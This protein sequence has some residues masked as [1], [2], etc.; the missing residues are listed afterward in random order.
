MGTFLPVP[1]AFDV[2]VAGALLSGGLEHGYVFALVFTLGSFSIYSWLIVGS[3]ISWRAA[4]LLGGVIVMLGALGGVATHYYH[5]WQTERA[6][7]MLL[8]A[9]RVLLPAAH[10]AGAQFAVTSERPVAVEV[11]PFAPRS[12]GGTTP[13]QRMDAWHAGID[14]PIEFSMKDMWPPFWEGRS[15]S[16]G[17]IDQDG[18]TDLVIASTEAGLYIYD[19]GGDGQFTRIGADL[20]ALAD[21]DIF[22][23]ALVDIDNDGWLDLFIAT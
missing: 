20:G 7:E 22:N 10:A 9:E 1:I 11:R 2:V 21:L 23:A 4:N 18:D 5:T 13:F 17:D 6:L 16:S 19:N 3:T 8:G 12:P 14:K 15:L